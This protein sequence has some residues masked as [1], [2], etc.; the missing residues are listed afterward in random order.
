MKTLVVYDKNGTI[1]LTKYPVFEDDTFNFLLT[2]IQ[3]NKQIIKV[4]DGKPIFDYLPEVKAEIE[5][6]QNLADNIDNSIAETKEELEQ[7]EKES[8]EIKKK[9]L[10]IE[11]DVFNER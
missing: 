8:L 6:L 11:G 1:V 3:K 9:L 7:K 5:K 10:D 4:E 2:D